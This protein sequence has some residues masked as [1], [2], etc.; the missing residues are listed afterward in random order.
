M[1]LPLFS[2]RQ[3]K[4]KNLKKKKKIFTRNLT[5]LTSPLPA[6][7][8]SHW[9]PSHTRVLCKRAHGWGGRT[10][11]KKKTHPKTLQTDSSSKGCINQMQLQAKVAE[12]CQYLKGKTAFRCCD[13]GSW[14]EICQS[15]C[16]WAAFGIC[17]G[18]NAA[19]R[20]WSFSFKL[21]LKVRK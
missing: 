18:H 16:F 7:F 13:T 3:L 12:T 1:H 10:K 11:H 5:S 21:F 2:R 8:S 6:L 14:I 19:S 17:Y 4:K 9:G 15:A 20:V